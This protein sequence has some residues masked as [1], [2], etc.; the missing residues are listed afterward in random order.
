M[1]RFSR[2][3]RI[4]WGA[5]AIAVIALWVLASLLTRHTM[6]EA[7]DRARR[8]TGN[9]AQTI[10]EQTRRTVA[11]ADQAL[12]FLALDIQ[13]LSLTSED[14]RL[15]MH[16]AVESSDTVLQLSYIGGNGILRETN[17]DG[18]ATGIDLSDR[19]H[20]R[21]HRDR[22]DVGLFISKPVYGR[23]SGR[24]SI[25]LTRR[26]SSR[27]G[28]F[29]GVIVASLDPFYFSHSFDHIDVGPNGTISI[30]GLDGI[31]RARSVLT[32]K[33]IGLDLGNAPIVR[34]ARQQEA[35]YL[36]STSPVDGIT[37]LQ[38][39]RRLPGYPL[40]VI[41]GVSED[42]FLAEARHSRRLYLLTAAGCTLAL[43]VLAG[44]A[45][46]FAG[47][48][49]NSQ[50]R[51]LAQSERLQASERRYRSVFETAGQPIIT[52]NESGIINGCNPAA[53][54]LFGFAAEEVLGRD[55]AR[56]MTS[57][58]RVGPLDRLGSDLD[59]DQVPVLETALPMEGHHQS[60]RE[61]PLEVTLSGWFDD[62]HPFFTVLVNDVTAH[63]EIE[64][65]LRR[66]RDDA[67][68]VSRMKGEFLATMSHEI[69]TPLNGILGALGL[70]D[71]LHL[72]SE[73]RHLMQ[74]AID[75]GSTLR[76]IIDDILDLSKL[77]SGRAEPEPLNFSPRDLVREIHTLFQPEATVRG[78]SLAVRIDPALPDALRADRN[79]IMQ[80]FLNLVGN[81]LKFTTK[82]R[83]EV[84]LLTIV[85]PG[86]SLILRGEVRDT[87]IGIDADILPRLFQRFTQ[88]DGSTTRRFGG[89]GLGLAICQEI[90]SLL[91]GQIGVMSKPGQGSLFWFTL[92]YEPV[93]RVILRSNPQTR[94]VDFDRTLR[95]LVAEDNSINREILQRILLRHGCVVLEAANG[96]EAVEKV[97]ECPLDL[98]LMDI[99]MPE[100]DGVEA[101]KLIRAL[102]GDAGRIPILA[103]T[104]NVLQEDQVRYLDAGMTGIVAKPITPNK[105]LNCVAQAVQVPAHNVT[106]VLAAET[107]TAATGPPTPEV[108]LLDPKQV[109][110]IRKLVGE[111]G[112]KRAVAMLEEQVT[113][114]IKALEYATDETEFRAIAHRL[115][116]V[117]GN[118][119][120]RYLSDVARDMER[121][122]WAAIPELLTLSE[123]ARQTGSA[124]L[125][126]SAPDA[127]A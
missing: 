10:A 95:I 84:S 5:T 85:G 108:S 86:N 105:L 111:A 96:R 56:L 1:R 60:G 68:S 33:T 77:E 55:V 50:A 58:G 122:G 123:T 112:W 79:R 25:Q 78:L 89:T 125:T 8:D 63:R 81:A 118:L 47:E 54:R 116:G 76:T 73:Q 27:D 18:A 90:C 103:V 37:R 11:G 48:Q 52:V 114:D 71:T 115:K 28:D 75:A 38:S 69:R 29:A 92:P 72:D 127:T 93:C 61:I 42:S 32:D 99:Q 19:E 74:I 46:R 120:A 59:A 126:C 82:G 44:V 23:A 121:R 39:F 4:I 109:L 15:F 14:I 117:A 31:L 26:I 30:I 17:I 13:R 113:G 104:A 51:L 98:V 12:H 21:V 53:Q 22:A 7:L 102:P 97:K 66:A 24:W 6:G 65:E 2:P 94:A 110:A 106:P 70:I 100:L 83:I 34:M 67:A 49:E 41:A 57:R 36:R 16:A 3:I 101:T 62:G 35:G 107:A 9:L 80:L 91:G 119:G 43:L 20:F 45:A 124:L 88:A 40:L 64:G 87:G